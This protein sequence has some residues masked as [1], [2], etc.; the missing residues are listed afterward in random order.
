MKLKNPTRRG[1]GATI[2]NTRPMLL[3]HLWLQIDHV[4]S[5]VS[6]YQLEYLDE[7]RPEKYQYT[8]PLDACYDSVVDEPQLS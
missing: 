6:G 8:N 3:K 5:H 2:S 4:S 1:F 7:K